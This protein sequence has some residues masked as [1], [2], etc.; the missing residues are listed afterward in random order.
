VK[1]MIKKCVE[2]VDVG[3]CLLSTIAGDRSIIHKLL[4][5]RAMRLCTPLL[6]LALSHVVS[7]FGVPNEGSDISRFVSEVKKC[8]TAVFSLGIA[9]SLALAPPAFAADDR[10]ATSVANAKITTGGASTLQSGRTI[11]ITRG[12]NLDFSDFSGQNLKGVAFQQS[13]VRDTNFKG[14]NLVGGTIIDDLPFV[15]WH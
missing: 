7:G 5:C 6:L 11:A 4:S 14:C 8:G 1:N 15:E 9:V 12:V 2:P 13:I 3:S 10:G